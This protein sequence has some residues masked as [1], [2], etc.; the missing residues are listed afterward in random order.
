M[1]ESVHISGSINIFNSNSLRQVFIKW[2]P[3]SNSLHILMKI[4]SSAHPR[5]LE[6]ES[7]N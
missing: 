3:V 4:N 5:S 1:N 6:S 2:V 7:L